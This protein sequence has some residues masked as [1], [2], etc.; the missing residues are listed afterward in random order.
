[1][2]AYA[3]DTIDFNIYENMKSEEFEYIDDLFASLLVVGMNSQIK[4]GLS[5][6][7][8][9]FSEELAIVRGKINLSDSIKMNSLMKNRLICEY[10]EYNENILLNQIIKTIL[11][12]LLNSS[13]V[14]KKNKRNIKRVLLYMDK[15]SFIDLSFIK[16]DKLQIPRHHSD[17]RVM[18]YIAYLYQQNHIF[19]N[20]KMDCYLKA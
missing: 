10:D 5:K 1:M 13:N 14:S 7:Y 3:F 2:I 12:N 11:F 17:Y 16:L 18:I 8:I 15:I 4:K 9:P 6:N 19:S 20:S